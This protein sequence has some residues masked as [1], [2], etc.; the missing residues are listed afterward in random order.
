MVVSFFSG[1]GAVY[2]KQ[3]FAEEEFQVTA[4]EVE[5]NKIVST[6]T[7]LSKIKTRPGD[8]ATQGTVNEDIKRLY[9]VGFFVD[10][11]AEIRPYRDGQLVRFKVKERPLVAGVVITGN[12]HFRENTLR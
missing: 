6:A 5:G 11:S 12:R 4:V 9:G 3:A 8:R 1:W 2:P 7:I 10:V